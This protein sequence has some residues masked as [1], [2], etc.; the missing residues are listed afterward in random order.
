MIYM[1]FPLEEA[2]RRHVAKGGKV[3]D[4]IEPVSTIERN[5]LLFSLTDF[6]LHKKHKI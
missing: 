4:L 3:K 6:I 5:F 2:I 1:E